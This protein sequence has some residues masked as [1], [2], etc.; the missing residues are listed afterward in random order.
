MVFKGDMLE[1]VRLLTHLVDN[2]EIVLFHTP[3]LH[4]ILGPKEI[5][6]LKRIGE[7]ENV[8]F[9]VHLPASLEIASQ[10]R[11]KREESVR[12]AGEIF[13]KMGEINPRYYI[14]HIPFSPPTLVAVPGLYFKT[15]E[16]KEWDE[17]T[18][19]ALESLEM[20]HGALGEDKKLL[21]ENIN[22]SPFFLEPF[23]K[24]VCCELCLDL[25]HMILGQENVT[26]LLKRYLEVTREIH[27]HGVKGYEE[28][29][30]LSILPKNRVRK[31][32]KVLSRTS[33]KGVIQLEV[34]SPQDLEESMD[35]IQEIL[36]QKG[37][38]PV[39]RDG[40]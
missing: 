8:S 36:F 12:L 25:G 21:V 31:W 34:F 17:W 20:L 3:T 39:V 2:I 23:W 38:V 27:L 28:H 24:K 32:L 14:L 7:Q 11:R 19:R 13:L 1:N 35:I 9:T 40:E 5:R 4:N 37:R 30:S 10:D 22:Y 29:L 18:S 26:G 15:G 33:F 6:L 16:K